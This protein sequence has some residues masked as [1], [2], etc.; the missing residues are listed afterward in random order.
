MLSASASGHQLQGGAS[1]SRGERS[2]S[3]SSEDE[4][5]P[6][7][8]GE[9]LHTH[10]NEDFNVNFTILFVKKLQAEFINRHFYLKQGNDKV[11]SNNIVVHMPV[12][13]IY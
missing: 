8:K 2:A 1:Y 9:K 3:L 10:K 7:P 6:F 13:G 12:T 5:N 4:R 11:A